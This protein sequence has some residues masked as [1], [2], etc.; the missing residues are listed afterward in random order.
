MCLLFFSW[1]LSLLQT[2]VVYFGFWGSVVALQEGTGK[3]K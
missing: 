2:V 1:F 3:K